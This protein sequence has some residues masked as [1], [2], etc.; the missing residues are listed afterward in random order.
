M[1]VLLA[2]LSALAYGTSDFVGGLMSTRIPAW[3]AAFCSQVGGAVAMTALALATGGSPTVPSLMWGALAGVATGVGV[4]ALYRGLAVGRMGVV[5]PVSGV[6]GAVLPAVVGLAGGERPS[7]LM[8]AGLL[9]ALPAVALV[10]SSVGGGAEDPDQGHGAGLLLGLGAGAGFGLGFTAI[11]QVPGSAGH[12]P[13]VVEMVAGGAFT[14]LAA[15]LAGAR[16]RPTRPADWWAGAGGTL[17]AA[18]LALFLAAVE[19]GMLSVAAVLSSLYPA[20][21][22]AWA[23]LF[24]SE[25]IHRAQAVGLGLC[26]VAVALV[27]VG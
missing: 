9:L 7:P 19:H 24:L 6:T 20:A 15:T 18:A 1:T 27:A 23:V 4:L 3:T 17:A 11:A 13:L 22:V 14:A 12:W 8:W 21:T 2:L 16:W 25:R 5:A 26:G 10:A